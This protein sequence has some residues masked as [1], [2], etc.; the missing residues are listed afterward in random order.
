MFDF[1]GSGG[2]LE[3]MDSSR[4]VAY[5]NDGKR[6][7]GL[8]FHEYMHTFNVKR[9]RSKPLGPFDYT[10]PALT[11]ALWWLEGVT[12]YYAD[13]MRHRSG[14]MSRAQFLRAMGGSLNTIRRNGNRLKVSAAEMSRRVWESRGSQGYQMSYYSKGKAVGVL[15]DLAIREGSGNVH[16]LD[17]VMTAL[18]RECIKGPGFAEGRIRELCIAYGGASLGPIY[19]VCVNQAANMPIESVLKSVGLRWTGSN[20]VDVQNVSAEKVQ[21]RKG[22]PYQISVE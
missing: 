1:G 8:I 12:D 13:V 18:Y 21:V 2:G 19:D 4:M 9:I 20:I 10:K 5:S 22:W 11:D 7:A 16:T 17:D 6:M 14:L 15:L 3:H